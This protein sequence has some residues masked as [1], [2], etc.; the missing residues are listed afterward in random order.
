M[1]FP[2][3]EKYITLTEKKLGVKFPRTFRLKMM[4]DNGGEVETPPDAWQLYPFYD[5]RSKKRIKRTCNDIVRETSN[6]KE[7]PNFPDGAVAI[8]SNG[9]GDQL[10]LLPSRETA[11]LREAIFWWDHETGGVRKV[12]DRFDEL[13]IV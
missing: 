9:G 6:A 1:P 7:W 11:E 12:A 8:G 5:T 4:K 10:V 2:L 3:D 13:K